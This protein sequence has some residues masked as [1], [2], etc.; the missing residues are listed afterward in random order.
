MDTTKRSTCWSL[1]I[2]NPTPDDEEQIHLARQMGWKVT[3]QLEAGTEGTPHYQL[4]LQTPQVRFSA[5]K[6][7]FPRAHIEPAREPKALA[8]YVEKQESRVAP[9]PVT[10]EK[11]PSLSRLWDLIDRELDEWNVMLTHCWEHPEQ[12]DSRKAGYA[13]PSP[14]EAFNYAIGKLIEKG[15][16]V[17][18]I[19]ANP[20]VISSW[21]KFHRS[22]LYRV[23]ADRVALIMQRMESGDLTQ[24][25]EIPIFV[26]SPPQSP[27]AEDSRP[28]S[29]PG[30]D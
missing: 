1:T 12:W 13:M 5:V 9:L 11:Y 26:P 21:K 2:N 30:T 3:G 23:R 17:E 7:L 10:Q 6:K 16:H 18:S 28:P 15:Y 4:M 25:A 14:L 27:R 24:H 22:I 29:P 20:M 8:A 19:G